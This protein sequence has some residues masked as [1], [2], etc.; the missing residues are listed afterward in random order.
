MAFAAS[1]TATPLW[2]RLYCKP[3]AK[4]EIV[5]LAS[6]TTSQFGKSILET[7][8]NAIL[9][10]RHT[11]MR[12]HRFY[13]VLASKRGNFFSSSSLSPSETIKDFYACINDRKLK[14][15]ADYISADCHI[16]E[17]SFPT[18]FEGREEV[19]CFFDQLI[20]SMGDN[21]KFRVKQVCEGD[22]LIAAAKWHIEW[23]N[24]EIPF[25]RG[26]SFFECSKEGGKL[27]IKYKSQR[28]F[29][30]SYPLDSVKYYPSFTNLLFLAGKHKL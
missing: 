22:E 15:L 3:S 29:P 19:L 23:K 6:K 26:C 13:P 11:K 5:F 25:T 2:Q 4:P 1:F 10:E 9:R 8:Q 28:R 14:R 24:A 7:N 27:V 16:E 30:Y 20:A 18:P 12:T 21:V 17:C